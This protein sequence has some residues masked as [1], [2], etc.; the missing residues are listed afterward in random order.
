[1]SSFVRVLGGYEIEDLDT[2]HLSYK[3]YNIGLGAYRELPWGTTVYGQVAYRKYDF[4]GLYPGSTE[5]RE[6]HRFDVTLN[7]TKRDWAILGYA[8]VLTYTYT[9]NNSNVGFHDYTAHGINFTVTKNF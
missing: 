7:L 9:V 8:P 5:N 2:E 1:P 4:D 3:S 6:D